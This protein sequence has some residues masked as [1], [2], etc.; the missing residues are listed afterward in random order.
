MEGLVI[1][2]PEDV[3]A[4]VAGLIDSTKMIL[5]TLLPVVVGWLM[6]HHADTPVPKYQEPPKP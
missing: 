6:R 5:N 4:L 1:I 2:S 3:H